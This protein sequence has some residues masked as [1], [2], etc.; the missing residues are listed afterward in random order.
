MLLCKQVSQSVKE[1]AMVLM[2]SM[3]ITK[4]CK[5]AYTPL[6]YV[7]TSLPLKRVLYI[8][9]LMQFK[10]EWTE[11]QAFLNSDSEINLMTPA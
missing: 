3:S 2:T 11:I 7:K 8:Y 10:I 6:I 5:E 4:A 1:L 9:H